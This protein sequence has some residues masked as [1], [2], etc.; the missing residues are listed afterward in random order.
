MP[1]Y[2][3]PVYTVHDEGSI[4]AL[5]QIYPQNIRDFNIPKVWK[6]TKGKGVVVAVLD[7]GCPK[8][9]PDLKNNI[10]ISK[11]RSFV[12]NEDI[13]DTTVGHGTHCSGTIGAVDNE[14]G[15][16]GMAPEVTLVSVKVLNK[17]GS[18]SNPS[19]IG[20]LLYCLNELKPDVINMSL[21]S[22]YPMPDIEK[23]L[24]AL[25]V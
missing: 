18:G 19:L 8:D 9:H 4:Q 22:S 7:T 3:L 2:S 16:V 21:G 14:E 6:K 5:S 15:I 1:D 10:D 20:G 11:S 17:N 12:P 23:I 24:K 25:K 13:Y